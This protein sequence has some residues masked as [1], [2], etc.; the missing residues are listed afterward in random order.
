MTVPAPNHQVNKAE[1]VKEIDLPDQLAPALKQ[2]IDGACEQLHAAYP[3]MH[4]PSE[5]CRPPHLHRD[6]LRNKLYLTQA[7][8]KATTPTELYA[9]IARV[10][11]ALAKR[12]ASQWPE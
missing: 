6:P 11:T 2:T 4:K 12:P 10:N 7:V 5:R 8:H 9:M 1:V 3:Q